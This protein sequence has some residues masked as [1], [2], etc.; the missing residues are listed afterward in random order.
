MERL[1][2]SSMYVEH[3]NVKASITLNPDSTV[4]RASL[5]HND[6]EHVLITD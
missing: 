1:I 6:D 5:H 2:R 3:L 4:V